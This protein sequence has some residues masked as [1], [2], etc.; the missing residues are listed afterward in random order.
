[1][2]KVKIEQFEG[3]LDLLLEIIEAKKLSL[4][5]IALSKVVDQ[6]VDYL[7][8]LK[9]RSIDEIVQFLVVASRLALLKSRELAPSEQDQDEGEGSIDKLQRQLALYQSYRRAAKELR[10]LARGRKSFHARESFAGFKRVFYFPPGLQTTDL[11]KALADLL[12]TITLP[13]KIPQA[14]IKDSVTMEQS[15][16]Q[17]AKILKAGK[18]VNISN[19]LESRGLTEKLIYFLSVLELLRL[20][21]ISINQRNNFGTIIV[22]PGP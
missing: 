2:Y 15:L 14:R 6:F 8:N 7:D 19:F 20:G 11:T 3:P 1:M 16:R 4:V 13:K 5:E 17:L 22:T 10:A 21:K 12:N 18:P 9:E